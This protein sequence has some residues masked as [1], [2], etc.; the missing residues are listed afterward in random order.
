M[1]ACIVPEIVQ[2][3][4]QKDESDKKQ[5]N[6]VY[7]LTDDQG[8]GDLGCMG[9]P[10]IKTPNIDNLYREGFSFADF[11]SGTTSAPTRSGIMTGRYCNT[12]GVWHTVGG[13]SLL[14]LEEKT[15]PELFSEAGYETGLFGKWHLGDNYP[16]RPHE[17]GFKEAYYHGGGGI[18]QVP[19]AWGN[20]YFGDTYFHNGEKVK[21][22]GYCTDFWFSKAMDFI[23]RCDDKPFFCYISTNAPHAP[24]N[25][26]KK[27]ADLYKDN[28]DV[29]NPRF[30]GMITNIDENV[31][32]LMHFLKQKDLLDNTIVVFMTDNGTASGVRFDKQGHLIKGYNA[33]MQGKKS[34]PYEGGHR[35]PFIVRIP[36]K[37]PKVIY[38]LSGYVDIMPT[39]LD[40]CGLYKYIPEDIDGQSLKG[41]FDKDVESDRYMFADTQRQEFLEKYRLS[42]VMYKKWRLVNGK[43]L[44]NIILDPGQTNDLSGKHP[45]LVSKMK[46]EYE[47]WWDKTSVRGNSY[48]RIVVGDENSKKV[49]L[50]S[51][52]L[53]EEKAPVTFSQMQVRQANDNLGKWALDV[54]ES[55]RYRITLYRWH[56]DCNLK[57]NDSI[58]MVPATWGY[59]ER[60]VDGISIKDWKKAEFL[61]DDVLKKSVRVNMNKKNVSTVLNLKAGKQFLQTDFINEAGKRTSAYFAII[62]KI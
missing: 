45:E 33:G 60:E 17:R 39:F 48:E 47:K 13:R 40:L 7:I 41:L 24:F 14:T 8:Y 27:Y 19:D 21:A 31:G 18:S 5:Y 16:Y 62:E 12:V 52:D 29:I 20:D 3:A 37:Q 6:I 34:S 55:G 35:V 46:A 25:V 57:M 22:E 38:S 30:Y 58:K 28:E 59:V 26:E 15:M 4:N 44:F 56:P 53:H 23:D 61:V 42:C 1:P 54:K 11:H 50:Y 36:H 43:E 9:N 10:Y 2:A 49:L 51:H 32:K